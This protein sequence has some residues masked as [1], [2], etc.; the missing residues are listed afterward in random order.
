MGS[1]RS[2]WR[3]QP[4]SWA[5]K[6]WQLGLLVK[7]VWAEGA[8][9]QV[10]KRRVGLV[11]KAGAGPPRVEPC[12]LGGGLAFLSGQQWALKGLEKHSGGARVRGWRGCR[13]SRFARDSLAS[14]KEV[15]AHGALS[16]ECWGQP[17]GHGARGC[18]DQTSPGSLGRLLPLGLL[19]GLRSES[20]TVMLGPD[21]VPGR[22]EMNPSVLA[23]TVQVPQRFLV[24][25]GDGIR[26][27]IWQ[28]NH[29]GTAKNTAKHNKEGICPISSQKHSGSQSNSHGDGVR[30][31]EILVSMGIECRVEATSQLTGL[32]P[33][34]PL[35]GWP[36]SLRTNSRDVKVKQEASSA[37][38]EHL[39]QSAEQRER[40]PGQDETRV[41]VGSPR[42]GYP[43]GPTTQDRREM[44]VAS[45]PSDWQQWQ[46]LP[47]P[48]VTGAVRKSVSG[49]AGGSVDC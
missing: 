39:C 9:W 29:P 3:R 49:A 34:V 33:A 36:S 44:Q 47:V 46:G 32:G 27:L 41:L 16:P 8:K 6:T 48:S 37:S 43:K 28:E 20:R 23:V 11:R 19:L 26:Q 5:G 18:L 12:M 30:L 31:K 17:G 4:A 40:T 21:S 15:Q 1:G 35:H 14:Q 24:D 13:I 45:Q 22:G 25:L 2:F 38:L 42:R 10:Q 7:T